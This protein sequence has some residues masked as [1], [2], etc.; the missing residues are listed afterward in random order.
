MAT[1][2]LGRLA[3]VAQL[4][5]GRSVGPCPGLPR[6]LDQVPVPK[7]GRQFAIKLSQRVVPCAV[8][9]WFGPEK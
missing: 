1:D 5:G 7:S 2:A 3:D 8:V 6:P 9:Y 4:G